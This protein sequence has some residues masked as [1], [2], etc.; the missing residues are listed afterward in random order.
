MYSGTDMI[1]VIVDK[2]YEVILDEEDGYLIDKYKWRIDQWGYAVTKVWDRKHKRSKVMFLHKMILINHNLYKEGLVIDHINREKLD[3]RKENLRMATKAENCINTNPI[4]GKYKGVAFVKNKFASNIMR[5]KKYFLGRYDLEEEAAY[6]YNVA[7]N[8][9]PGGEFNYFNPVDNLL[10]EEKKLE[11]EKAVRERLFNKI[12][13]CHLKST[14]KFK[15]VALKKPWVS[16]FKYGNRSMTLGN[17]DTEE[18]AA[19]AY[20]IA[21]G[22]I[23]KEQVNNVTGYLSEEFKERLIQRVVEFAKKYK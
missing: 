20:D 22:V 2:Y 9:L 19:E 12:K 11:V 18:E 15:G 14:S 3:N 16:G 1:K 4:I 17:F 5:G 10:S 7:A 13:G 21:C 6:A 23:G 8:L